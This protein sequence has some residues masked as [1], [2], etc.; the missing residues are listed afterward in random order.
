[1]TSMLGGST[2]ND[3]SRLILFLF[4]CRDRLRGARGFRDRF[5]GE[6]ETNREECVSERVGEYLMT[7]RWCSARSTGS[8]VGVLGVRAVMGELELENCARGGD[9][10]E[11]GEYG[12]SISSGEPTN[13]KGGVFVSMC[14]GE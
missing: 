12:E 14:A 4:L 13:S 7:F 11:Y 10:G 6:T 2:E 9:C 5:V 8:I 1:M 3:L